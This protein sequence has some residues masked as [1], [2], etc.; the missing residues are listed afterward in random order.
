MRASSLPLLLL[1]TAAAAQ[2]NGNITCADG[3]YMIVARGTNE[4]PGPGVMGTAVADVVA[5]RIAGSEVV[6]L[7][8][9]ASFGSPGYFESVADGGQA[10]KDAV[11][12]YHAAC[13]DGKMAVLGYSQV[14]ARRRPTVAAAG[15]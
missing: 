5:D 7:D 6:G 11:E 15:R 10:V 14:R 13:P 1:S 2:D 9:P 12:E 8:Y 3:L 4:D